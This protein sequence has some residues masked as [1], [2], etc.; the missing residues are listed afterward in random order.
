MANVKR[1]DCA[2][3]PPCSKTVRNKLQRA[4]YVSIIWGNADTAYPPQLDPLQYGWSIKNQ[5]YV[6]EW[7]EEPALPD[8]LQES[9]IDDQTDDSDDS[10]AWSDD[11]DTELI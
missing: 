11:S 1:V 7:F 2:L 6:P 4:H 3:L 9:Q 5:C 10:N 8:D